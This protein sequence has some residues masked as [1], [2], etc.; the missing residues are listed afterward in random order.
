MKNYKLLF[1]ILFITSLVFFILWYQSKKELDKYYQ[2]DIIY[3]DV[4][5]SK[6][7]TYRWK[8]NN[9]LARK[10]CNIY[11][12]GFYESIADYNLYGELVTIAQDYNHDG[13]FEVINCY[14]MHEKLVAKY[15]D[16]DDDGFDDKKTIMLNDSTKHVY[17][18]K[19]KNRI[20]EQEEKR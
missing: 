10:G 17:I 7:D 19:N 16:T 11:G 14:N 6:C 4:Q 9:K 18:D 20:Y 12:A 3:L 15:E 2:T 5:D 1:L 13:M 8:S